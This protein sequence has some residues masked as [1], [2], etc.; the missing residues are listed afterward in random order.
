MI[1]EIL[2]RLLRVPVPAPPDAV[3][4]IDQGVY[5]DSLALRQKRWREDE[6]EEERQRLRVAYMIWEWARDVV[7]KRTKLPL[8]AKLPRN[9]VVRDWLDGLW[10]QE[11]FALSQADGGEILEHIYGS[12][13]ITN[14]RIV[15]KLP[16]STL[17][18]PAPKAE[19]DF[20]RPGSG[21]G[22]RRK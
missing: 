15:Q 11:I 18:F 7:R 5:F 14:V 19:P 8:P 21:G 20:S 9:D 1:I 2:R 6:E 10:V 4:Y 22:P 13:R 17:R 12:E 16:V 3:V